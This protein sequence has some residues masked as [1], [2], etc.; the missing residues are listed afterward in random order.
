MKSNDDADLQRLTD[1]KGALMGITKKHICCLIFTKYDQFVI[2]TKHN[3][4]QLVSMLILIVF[5][6]NYKL[7]VLFK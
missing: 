7:I 5:C 6:L 2:E 3:K 1:K 4:N